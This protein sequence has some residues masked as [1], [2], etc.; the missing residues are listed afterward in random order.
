[1]LNKTWSVDRCV[2]PLRGD[3]MVAGLSSAFLLKVTRSRNELSGVIDYLFF[4]VVLQRLEL[5]NKTI[6]RWAVAADRGGE[7]PIPD[8]S[9]KEPSAEAEGPIAMGS[10]P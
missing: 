4:E 2:F 5:S 3:T 1:M 9:R 10:D 8:G 7:L 6:A